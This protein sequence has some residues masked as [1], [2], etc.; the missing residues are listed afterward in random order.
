MPSQA[1]P[2]KVSWYGVI[3]PLTDVEGSKRQKGN[4]QPASGFFPVPVFLWG[5]EIPDNINSVFRKRITGWKF[6]RWTVAIPFCI[7]YS[8]YSG[9]SA[10][11]SL[12]PD[13][14]LTN[15][16]LPERAHSVTQNNSLDAFSRIYPTC[17]PVSCLAATS[18]V[19]PFSVIGNGWAYSIEKDTVYLPGLFNLWH[20]TTHGRSLFS[21]Q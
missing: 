3:R 11:R 19:S 2:G 20:L 4:K 12:F 7:C 15:S 10:C 9:S 21:M 17:C 1:P 5:T 6:L 13:L 14:L 8:F 18:G 16:L